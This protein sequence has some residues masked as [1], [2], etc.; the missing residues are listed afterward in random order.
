MCATVLIPTDF[1]EHSRAIFERLDQI[2]GID[3]IVLLHV[4]DAP[5]AS[6]QYWISGKI[7]RSPLDAARK[8]LEA[9]RESLEAR[10]VR[11]R[12]R[13]E[14]IEHG[15]V[16]QTIIA[17]A[18][19]VDASLIVMG[20]RG[21]G[22]I[23]GL[24]LGSVSSGVL[25]RSRRN[26][27]IMHPPRGGAKKRPLFS[28]VLAPVDFSRPTEEMMVF[29]RQVGGP[30]EL[31]L[32]HVIRSAESR[33]E[34]A[35]FETTAT[36]RL[37][38]MAAEAGED[39]RKVTTLVRTGNPADEI[40][41][42]A[43]AE[44]VSLIIMPRCGKADYVRN[45]QLGGTTV[46][47]V[48]RARRPVFV[49]S[50]QITLE[51]RVRE[52][53]VDEFARAEE[54]WEQYRQQTANPA[55]DRIFGV[56]VESILAGVARCKV[57]ADGLEVD[58]VFVLPEFR[59]RGYAR[60]AMQALLDACGDEI[61]YMHATLDLIAFYETFGFVEIPESELPPTIRERF[62]F[63]LGEMEGMNVQPMRRIPQKE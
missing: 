52:L 33:S 49:L 53:A 27:L 36:Q 22:I 12:T 6:T 7:Y 29:L 30:G 31:I 25:R 23:S 5:R 46:D 37:E 51:V 20:A 8:E 21:R 16:P 58:G 44:D 34:L 14:F 17:V 15:D 50:P 2:P 11:V 1:S 18:E 3:E 61:L 55:T 62:R 39:Q 60:M 63:A 26:V 48:K 19:E 28:R 32:L 24:I 13:I 42:V 35:F 57:H 43:E 10:G 56:F 9:L 59:K 38:R 45:V 41:E 54:V 4:L 40:C 47:V